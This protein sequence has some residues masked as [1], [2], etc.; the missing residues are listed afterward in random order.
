MP[1][2]CMSKRAFKLSFY[3][4]S[5][6]KSVL[7]MLSHTFFSMC[8]TSKLCRSSRSFQYGNLN[9]IDFLFQTSG[10]AFLPLRTG[11]AGF[12]VV[13]SFPKVVLIFVVSSKISSPVSG[14]G[15]AL[16]SIVPSNA[17]AAD[18]NMWL[19]S[20]NLRWHMYTY[21]PP[22]LSWTEHV[23]EWHSGQATLPEVTHPVK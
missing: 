10:G 23:S 2:L 15:A 22:F 5:M 13:G 11:L 7:I 4:P 8:I 21:F 6:S 3:F 18:L 19:A 1:R 20:K 12:F 17:A 14:V 16:C 9:H